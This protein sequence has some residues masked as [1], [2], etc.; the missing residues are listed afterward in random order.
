VEGDDFL[1]DKLS[2][3]VADC[4][5]EIERLN[6][7]VTQAET[8]ASTDAALP[9]PPYQE[10]VLAGDQQSESEEAGG[11][12]RRS[13]GCPGITPS[14]ASAHKTSGGDQHPAD[15]LADARDMAEAGHETGCMEK[16][17]QLKDLLGID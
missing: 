6:E 16:V 5:Q 1:V 8:G 7:A 3:R 10:E 14:A 9:A 2:G 17:T 13:G 4:N 15:I 12:Q 11:H